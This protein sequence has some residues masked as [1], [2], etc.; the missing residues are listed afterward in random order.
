METVRYRRGLRSVLV[1][2]PLEI[3][4]TSEAI[5][6]RL[7]QILAIACITPFFLLADFSNDVAYIAEECFTMCHFNAFRGS[8][9]AFAKREQLSDEE[10]ADRLLYIA[11][12]PDR[13]R[14][15]SEDSPMRDAVGALYFFPNAIN[16]LT[17]L[18]QYILTPE[19]RAG[20]FADYGRITRYDDR[21]FTFTD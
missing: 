8:L 2:L 19:T 13:F 11:A 16:A 20:A 9:L 12:N 18:E 21:F 17:A 1:P 10:M 15:S 14:A 5:M 4:F 6:P 3:L 7:Q